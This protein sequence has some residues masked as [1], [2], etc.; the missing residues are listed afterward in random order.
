MIPASTREREGESA[1]A[2]SGMRD[3]YRKRGRFRELMTCIGWNGS[4]RHTVIQHIV[5]QVPLL[6]AD[7]QPLTCG[8][9]NGQTGRDGR[10][11][12]SQALAFG[13]GLGAQCGAPMGYA[14]S[15]SRTLLCPHI[16]FDRVETIYRF[17]LDLIPP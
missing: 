9:A 17:Q 11:T 4:V 13:G 6:G 15:N 3:V 1:H 2:K 10:P 5:M 8:Y 16:C 14:S 12:V 7:G